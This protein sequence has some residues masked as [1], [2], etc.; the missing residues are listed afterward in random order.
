MKQV[1]TMTRRERRAE[2]RRRFVTDKE[3]H[4]AARLARLD[5]K[6]SNESDA[7][8]SLTHS[9]TWHLAKRPNGPRA[10]SGRGWDRSG[11]TYVVGV[12]DLR[13][14]SRSSITGGG[15]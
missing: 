15:G 8:R 4:L 2:R 14:Q 5:Y 6:V 11:P 12:R 10:A 7:L 1:T 3:A 9:L 13:F